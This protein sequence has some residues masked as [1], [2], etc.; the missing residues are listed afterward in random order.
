M[1]LTSEPVNDFEDWVMKGYEMDTTKVLEI[2]PDDIPA[3]DDRDFWEDIPVTAYK[4][5]SSGESPGIEE[6]GE[7]I[8]DADGREYRQPALPLED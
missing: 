1:F 6:D 8:F 2:D 4:D 5:E 3:A 7:P